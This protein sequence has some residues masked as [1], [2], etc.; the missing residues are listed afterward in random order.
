MRLIMF[1]V[2]YAMTNH[3]PA[4]VLPVGDLCTEMQAGQSRDC[5][6]KIVDAGT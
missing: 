3:Y 4:A 2:S 5:G 1:A 6:K